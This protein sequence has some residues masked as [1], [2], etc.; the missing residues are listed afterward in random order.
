MNGVSLL[1]HTPFH[2]LHTVLFLQFIQVARSQQVHLFLRQYPD[3]V[4]HI[5]GTDN[6]IG[7][8]PVGKGVHIFDEHASSDRQRSTFANEPGMLGQLIPT[9]SVTLTAK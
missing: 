1:W 9:T 2:N 8:L 5:V 3:T 6:D 4:F 7:S